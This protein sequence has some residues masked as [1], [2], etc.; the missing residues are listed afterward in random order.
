MINIRCKNCKYCEY[1]EFDGYICKKFN[2]HINEEIVDVEV[3]CMVK[4][5]NSMTTEIY[6]DIDGCKYIKALFHELKEF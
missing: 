6:I 3:D 4:E 2:S 5:Y 1:V